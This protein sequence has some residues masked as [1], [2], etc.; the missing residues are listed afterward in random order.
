MTRGYGGH[1]AELFGIHEIDGIVSEVGVGVAEQGIPPFHKLVAILI[2]GA[3][4]TAEHA[5]RKLLSDELDEVELIVLESR[6]DHVD[7]ELA[8]RLFVGF[9]ACLLYTSPSPRDRG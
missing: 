6:F 3:E 5:H 9:D 4:Q 8:D 1:H 2:A 7:R